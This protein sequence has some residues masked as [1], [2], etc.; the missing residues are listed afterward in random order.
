MKFLLLNILTF[1]SMFSFAQVE[2]GQWRFHVATNKAVDVAAGNNKVFAAYENGLLEYDL[3]SNE[4][5]LW[6]KVNGL[7]DIEISKVFY[8]KSAS[9]LV[10]GYKNGN[11]D[12]LAGNEITNVP[13]LFLA[14]IP[15]DKKIYN[16][17]EKDKFIYVSTGMGILKLDPFKKEIKD[18]YYPLQNV[19]P[20]VDLAIQND[21][22]YVLTPTKLLKSYFLNPL[23]VDYSQ[24]QNVLNLPVLNTTN[25]FYSEIEFVNSDFYLLKSHISYGLDTV[26]NVGSV[27]NLP[28]NNFGYTSNI[29]HIKQVNNQLCVDLN[30]GVV[31]YLNNL[32]L[33]KTYYTYGFGGLSNNASFFSG[34]KV[35]IAD[36]VYG[37]VQFNNQFSAEVVGVAGMPKKTSYALDWKNGKLCVAGGMLDELAPSF[38]KAGVYTF[39]DEK[40]SIV[41]PESDPK[42]QAS[43]IWDIISVAINSN[44]IDQIAAGSASQVAL[45]IINN[46]K[47]DTIFT[48]NN[49]LLEEYIGRVSV[50]SLEYD[51]NG[52]LW[53]LN[54]YAI[55]PLKVYTSEKI[56]YNMN[57]NLV[58]ETKWGSKLIIDKDGNKWF[59]QENGG[60]TGY[61]DN[62]T[63]SN[64]G[65][66]VMVQLNSGSNTGNLPSNNVNTI[67]IDLDN[68]LWIGTEAGFAILYNPTGA[69]DAS[70]G[71]Y[72]AQRIKIEFEGN[73][74]YVLG[75]TNIKDIEVDG[76]NRKWIAT[77]NAGIVLLSSDGSEIIKQFTKE[78][79][80]LISNNIFD[81]EID[82]KTG[83]LFI[84]T[85]VGL[86]SYR[87]DASEGMTTYEDV[88][89]FPNPVRPNYNGLITI[90]GIKYDSDVKITDAGGNLVYSTTSNGG[91]ATWNGKTLKGEDVASGVYLIWTAPNEG[92]GRKVG[93]VVVI[94]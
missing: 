77:A 3:A 17:F 4:K 56:W 89:V 65:D 52:N 88:T 64:T 82:N 61:N 90:Q 78:N 30:D 16:F 83:E 50:K 72:N 47:V 41:N 53:V 45:S 31:L 62:T 43:T 86:V 23:I 73:I 68:E 20:F 55:K 58:N 25:E 5:S 76:G 35:F 13:G 27:S 57:T 22:M 71:E 42:W 32:T 66:D 67:A 63:I 36:G 10:I 48:K 60:V 69:F 46:G 74:E 33:D 1:L 28:I 75:N 91:T 93:K 39:E 26:Y 85:D 14:N 12:I 8:S 24:W 49:S 51:V 94:R 29:N 81:I 87:S 84:V 44:N 38:S 19:E 15:G 70:P 92:K 54:D 79:S 59:C 34:G 21:T 18:T 6:T 7:S 9:L 40:W 2:M 80:P 11:L 37:L